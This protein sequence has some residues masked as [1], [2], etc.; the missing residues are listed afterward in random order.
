MNA[1]ERDYAESG[2]DLQY[3]FLDMARRVPRGDRPRHVRWSDRR[4]FTVDVMD[5][6]PEGMV[7]GEFLSAKGDVMQGFD[8]QLN[9]WIQLADGSRVEHLRSWNDPALEPVVEYEYACSDGRL[10]VT[11][12]FLR[13]DGQGGQVAEKWTGNAGFY[14]EEIGPLE[15]VYRCSHGLLPSPDFEALVFRVTVR[16]KG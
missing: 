2:L 7:R 4:V 12:V 9:G 11:N 14:V 5:V 6:P 1:E 3:A 13:P 16:P 10:W 15:R 8:L